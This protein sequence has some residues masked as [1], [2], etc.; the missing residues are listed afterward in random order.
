MDYSMITLDESIKSG[1]E[2]IDLL[3]DN[4]FNDA[5]EFCAQHADE[6][7]YHSHGYSLL[8][9]LKAYLSL[10]M[11]SFVDIY[12]AFFAFHY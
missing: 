10:E 5:L 12:E 1:K 6:C 2:C 4:R 11:V 9:W 8:L 7:M 3:L